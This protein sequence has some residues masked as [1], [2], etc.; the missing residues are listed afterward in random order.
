M[1]NMSSLLHTALWGK[2]FMD[3]RFSFPASITIFWRSV[4]HSCGLSL[5]WP[6]RQRQRRQQL[7]NNCLHGKNWNW[8]A[9]HQSNARTD[10]TKQYML[11]SLLSFPLCSFCIS[12][13]VFSLVVVF[14]IILSLCLFCVSFILWHFEC[15]DLGMSPIHLILILI[16]IHPWQLTVPLVIIIKTYSQILN[17]LDIFLN[18]NHKW[19]TKVPTSHSHSQPAL[20]LYFKRETLVL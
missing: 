12:I 11:F 18:D 17:L 7:Q 9:T 1:S 2:C 15:G 19:T 13:W 5:C 6:R 10:L 3:W 16:L 14:C 8:Q 4:C 20:L